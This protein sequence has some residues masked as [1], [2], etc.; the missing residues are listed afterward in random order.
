[1]FKRT[2]IL[3]VFCILA[4]PALLNAQVSV[5]GVV[6]DQQTKEPIAGV[7]I[8][9]KGS[10]ASSLTNDYGKFIISSNDEI[11]ELIITRIGYLKKEVSLNGTK[12]PLYI[13]LTPSPIELSGVE[14]VGNNQILNAQSIGKLTSQDLD[15]GNGLSLERSINTIPGVFMQSRTPWG[16]ARIT[17]RGYYP[18]TS[19]NSP[20]SNGLGYQ[21][22]LDNIPITDA[23]GLTVLDDIDFS[24]LGSVEVIKGP[25]SSLYGSFIGG[26]LNLFTARSAPD[27]T[28]IKQQTI[29]GSYGLF[30]SNTSFQSAGENSDVELNYGHQSYNS[31]REHSAS[32]KDYFR[33]N[34]DFEAG[35]DQSISAYFSYN[36]SYEELAGEIDSAAFYN[37]IPE[38]NPLYLA[39]DSHI[40][41]ESFRTGITDD[42][43][44]NENFGNQTTVFGS[45][46]TSDQPFA[47]GFTDVNQFNY[48]LRSAFT[49]TAQTGEVGINGKL[50][51]MFQES[52]LTSN[53]VFIIPAPPFLQIPNDQE[54]YALNYYF[55]TEWSLTLPE[56]FIVTAGASLNKN[57]FGIRNML[58]AGQVYNGSQTTVNS[59]DPVFAP[60]VSVLKVLNNNLSVYASIGAG[61]TPP[62]LSDAVA[63]DGT[64]DNSLKPEKAVQYELGTKGNIL[65]GKIAYQLSLFDLENT[66][67]LVR[68]TMN[69]VTFTTNAGR[70]RNKGLELS[71]SY[72]VI[73]NKD[74]CISL[75][76]PWVTYTYSDFKYI[77]FKSDNNNNSSTVDFSGNSV[78]RVPK[79][80]FNAGINL[81]TNLGFYLNGSFQFVDKVPITF[82]NST[83]VKSYNL[84]DAKVGYD[85][86]ID[87]HWKLELSA[88]GDNLL[89]STYYTFLFTGPNIAG[90]KQSQDGGSG[91]GYIIPGPYKA[92]F[93]GAITISYIL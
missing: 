61:Y 72:L 42:Y 43:R 70:Q 47:H 30:R 69:S 51:G 80:M 13:L 77:D 74:Q 63:S 59:F 29:G 76:R 22:F 75:L 12:E 36:R 45:G 32:K 17:I 31:F 52:K 44:F 11:R 3:F 9:V 20:N 41:I 67:K 14:V 64:I 28:S 56:Q 78:A 50:G 35:S 5:K 37:R 27:Q 86:Q 83:Y 79:N 85:K 90:L 1:M 16:G 93:Y 6:V 25:S 7:L 33:I 18:S 92:T 87:K 24:S 8:F 68:Q 2:V 21:V 55:F 46:R 65:G 54:D 82:D 4:F 58:S 88:G 91:D 10:S 49:L 40:K 84:L 15:R 57:E 39:N 81:E 62:L 26:T 73:N 60:V 53:G 89:S 48:G 23:S 34:G 71:L 38:S 66:N 19:G